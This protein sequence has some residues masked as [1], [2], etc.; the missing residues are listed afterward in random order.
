MIS[1]IKKHNLVNADSH[2]NHDRL[3][4]AE[5][6]QMHLLRHESTG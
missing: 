2:F 4:R 3:I 6:A 1:D 5:S